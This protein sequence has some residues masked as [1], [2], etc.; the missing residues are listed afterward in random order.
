MLY[1]ILIGKL[2]SVIKLYT[3][4]LAEKTSCTTLFDY[5]FLAFRV[6]RMRLVE[7]GSKFKVHT[8]TDF[9]I[10]WFFLYLLY[11]LCKNIIVISKK[12]RSHESYIL[13]DKEK[14]KDVNT[15]AY[16]R[17]RL[18]KVLGSASASLI[19]TFWSLLHFMKG[20]FRL[21]QH[22]ISFAVVVTWIWLAQ[23]T[24]PVQI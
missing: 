9:L 4:W 13:Y 16:A 19:S 3:W 18:K 12:Y 14:C 8:F 21:Y 23:A 20:N 17:G 24:N 7:F 2:K 15:R 6:S 5:S 1:I 11:F 10:V 22:F